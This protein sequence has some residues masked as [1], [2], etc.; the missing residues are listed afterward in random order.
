[1]KLG[2]AASAATGGIV[3]P[4]GRRLGGETGGGAAGQAAEVA[5]VVGLLIGAGPS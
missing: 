5:A 1:V 4:A 3:A 2:A